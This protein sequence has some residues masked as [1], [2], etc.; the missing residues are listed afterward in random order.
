MQS[1][2]PT[3]LKHDHVFSKAQ[4]IQAHRDTG[5]VHTAIPNPRVGDSTATSGGGE[6]KYHTLSSSGQLVWKLR[7]GPL[8]S[9]RPRT[10]KNH[11]IIPEAVWP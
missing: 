8:H 2:L 9:D 11:V 6:P 4:I 7:K 3:I 10:S 5:F 1:P